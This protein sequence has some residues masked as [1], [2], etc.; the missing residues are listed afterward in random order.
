MFSNVNQV[1]VRVLVPPKRSEKP[2]RVSANDNSLKSQSKVY[3]RY[4]ASPCCAAAPLSFA[5]IKSDAGKY[6]LVLSLSILICKIVFI[7]FD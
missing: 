2:L 7:F 6:L 3:L 1:C 4:D 5:S